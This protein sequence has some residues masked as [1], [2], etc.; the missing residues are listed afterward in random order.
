MDTS[1][2]NLNL[3]EISACI[4]AGDPALPFDPDSTVRDM[5]ALYYNQG[6]EVEPRR[7]AKA[8][9]GYSLEPAYPNPFNISTRLTFVLPQNGYVSLKVYDLQGREIRLLFDNWRHTGVY[10]MTFDGSPYSS[11]IY[12][13]RMRSGAFRQTQRLV[14]IK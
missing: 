4:D 8:P 5:G 13:V 14:L 2:G 7:G 10:S 11:G 6:T 12:F 9:P 1:T 3:R